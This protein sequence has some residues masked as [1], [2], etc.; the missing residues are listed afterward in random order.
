MTLQLKIDF[1]GM[2]EL[3]D[4]L[5]RYVTK[6]PKAANKDLETISEDFVFEF[7]QE[8]LSRFPELYW[9]GTLMSSIRSEK[10]SEGFQ[11]PMSIHGIL[12][13]KMRPHLAPMW[14]PSPI[15]GTILGEWALE[16]FPL[17]EKIPH[18]LYVKPHPWMRMP[19]ER[20]KDKILER[21]ENGEF[22]KTMEE[23]GR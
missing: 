14:K 8:L 6:L 9:E 18:V 4:T 1:K 16:K 11:I 2:V 13:D 10:S 15:T 23:R 12:L 20:A 5:G 17:E 7:K 19:I 3:R 21:L 22:H